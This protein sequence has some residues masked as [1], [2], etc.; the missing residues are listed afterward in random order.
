VAPECAGC[1]V[2]AKIDNE[3][4]WGHRSTLVVAIFLLLITLLALGLRL[5]RLDGQSLWYDEGFSV[6]LA[7]MNLGEITERTAADIQPP[8]YYYLLHGWIGL[9]G[10]TEWALR[11]LSL[12]FGVFTVPLLYAAA[13]QL[14]RSR[15]AGLLAAL[16]VAISPLHVWY[17]Q[18]ARMYTLLTFLCLLSSYLLLLV[19]DAKK[20]W[21]IPILWAAYTLTNVAALYTHYFA[22]FVLAFQ[23]I[24]VF[25][26]WVARGGHPWHLVLGGLASGSATVLAYLPWIPYLF[27]RFGADVSYWPGQLNLHEVFVDVVVSFVGGESVSE[28]TGILLAI[29]Y[30]LI[31]VGCLFVLSSQAM[32]DA[33]PSAGSHMDAL[34]SFYSSLLF[35][36]LYLL[37]PPALILVLSYNSPKFNARYVMIS[38]PALLLIMSGGLAVLWQR[39]SGFLGNVSRGVL[40]ALALSFILVGA[41]YAN[42]NAYS[43]SAFA[44]SDFRGVARYLRR[45]I[46]PDEAIILTSG[47][48]FPV[49]D[50]YAPG[51]ERHL[52]PDSP[53]LDTTRTLD[54]SIAADLN[55]WLA[56]KEGLWLVL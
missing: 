29:G 30:G 24:Y 20:K 13:W 50:Y 46:G 34:S 11:S 2:T 53:T 26:I 10:D 56:G 6:Y 31:F 36:L 45:H 16:L 3:R 39:R 32:H 17:G 22:A 7:R 35:L 48:M 42:Y 4:V 41:I 12:L 51:V 54:Y 25:V 8:L 9:F 49:F 55:E 43:D 33:R 19:V 27:A 21:V 47:H 1:V 23:A 40:V 44:R 37:L 14:F 18:E 28:A 38:H 5:Y 52:L 15:L